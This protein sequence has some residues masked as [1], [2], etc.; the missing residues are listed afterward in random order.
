MAKRVTGMCV[1]HG[2]TLYAFVVSSGDVP[3]IKLYYNADGKDFDNFNDMYYFL[4][5]LLKHNNFNTKSFDC[6]GRR[7]YDIH[8]IDKLTPTLIENFGYKE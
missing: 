1:Y 6:F 7:F 5:K 4:L 2:T 3:N 8:F